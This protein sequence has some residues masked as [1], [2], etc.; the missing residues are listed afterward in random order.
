MASAHNPADP[1]FVPAADVGTIPTRREILAHEERLP[2][3]NPDA[4]HMK[5]AEWKKTQVRMSF[6]RSIVQS[7]GQLR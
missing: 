6:C 5:L 4:G 2:A 7:T 3:E 1:F